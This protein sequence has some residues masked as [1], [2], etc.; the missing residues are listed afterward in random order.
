MNFLGNKSKYPIYMEQN[1]LQRTGIFR[2]F[3][4]LE[5]PRFEIQGIFGA[6]IAEI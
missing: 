3:A 2:G 5:L 1:G 4:T 6:L